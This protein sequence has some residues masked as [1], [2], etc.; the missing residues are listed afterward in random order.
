MIPPDLKRKAAEFLERA[1]NPPYW[2][3]TDAWMDAEYFALAILNAANA[4]NY[5]NG[6]PY[7]EPDGDQVDVKIL[8]DSITDGGS[9][10]VTWEWSYWRSIH[11]EVMTHR[12]LSRNA[13][14]S[15]AIPM[16]K[17][18]ERVGAFPAMPVHWG[19]NKAGMQ[20]DAEIAETEKAK[21]WWIA[22]RDLMLCMH[23]EG[24]KL[25]LHKQIV[26][27]IIEPWMRITVIVSMTDH[28]NL[29][30]LRKHPDAE[31]N[32]QVIA[33]KAWDLFHEST[34]RYAAPGQWHLPLT[35]LEDYADLCETAPKSERFDYRND[36]AREA[37]KKVSVGRC[38]RVSYLTH[39]GRRDLKEDIELHDRL[40]R[41]ATMG[42]DPMHASPFEHVAVA[43]GG[44]QRIG[45]FEGWKQYRKCFP[46]ENG[47]NTDDRCERCGC[48][49]TRHTKDCPAQGVTP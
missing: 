33:N 47:P 24:E 40:A 28:A 22:A 6:A 23:E 5:S 8:A 20:A 3:N 34:P 36:F 12:A 13:A 9:R 42:E 14:S 16:K 17:L 46:H 26:N 38:A 27:R 44:R 31:P 19:A 37:I 2:H 1:K 21:R 48:W 29:F 11:S 49:A 35:T 45:N 7:E 39:D 32:F 10:L 43:V 41:A 18:R 15:R 25:G 4:A 30:H